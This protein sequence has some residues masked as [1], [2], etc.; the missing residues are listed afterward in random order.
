MT[1]MGQKTNIK[2]I[3]TNEPTQV[4][5]TPTVAHLASTPSNFDL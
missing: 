5:Q 2:I 3:E 1:W 4:T